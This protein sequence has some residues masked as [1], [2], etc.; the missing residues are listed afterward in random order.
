MTM[1]KTQRAD[2]RSRTRRLF[3]FSLAAA[4]CLVIS[5]FGF[6]PLEELERSLISQ[7]Q[8]IVSVIDTPVTQQQALPPP[9]P[10]PAIPIE[11]PDAT[12]AVP[13]IDTEINPFTVIPPP[14]PL[15]DRSDDAA[16][17]EMIWEF[18]EEYPGIVGGMD[19][20]REALVYP[21]IAVRA[22]I[23]GTVVVRALIDRTGRVVE[24]DVSHGLGGGCDEAAMEAV[25]GLRFTPGKQ[26]D[27]PVNVR[28][29]IPVQFR[30]K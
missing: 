18:V 22:G 20:L 21:D 5:A 17:E 7:A 1:Q 30:L 11:V 27:V 28:I 3:E 16:E 29:S 10:R 2:I 13:D 24:V 19:A 12:T 23:E 15:Q 8:D 9:P 26:R 6:F 25:R 4:L 14:P